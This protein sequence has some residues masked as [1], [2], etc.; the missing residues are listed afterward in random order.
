MNK[1]ETLKIVLKAS[2]KNKAM[3]LILTRSIQ[4]NVNKDNKLRPT[5][6]NKYKSMKNNF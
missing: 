4:Y 2:H 3:R 1:N 5:I 6:K